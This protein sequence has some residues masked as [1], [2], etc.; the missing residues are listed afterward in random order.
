[1]PKINYSRSD[2][3]SLNQHQLLS[4]VE[5]SHLLAS[6]ITLLAMMSTETSK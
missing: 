1:M 6:Y 5:P 3:Q 2:S 4:H